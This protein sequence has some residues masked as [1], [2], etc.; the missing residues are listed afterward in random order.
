LINV[1][2]RRVP[3][4]LLDLGRRG[5]F[6]LRHGGIR[7][8]GLFVREE[9]AR[10]SWI[11]LTAGR[12]PSDGGVWCSACGWSGRR[13]MTHCGAGYIVYQAMCPSCGAFPRHRGFA[14]LIDNGLSSELDQLEGSGLRLL[15]APERSMLA[16][17]AP[18]VD[19][20]QGV[21]YAPINDLVE[22][23]EDIQELSFATDSVDFLSCF[24][25][26]EHV[27][28]DNRALRELQR[29]I[30]PQGRA[31]VNVPITFGRRDTIEFGTPNPLLNDHYFDYGEDFTV[32]VV[33]AGLSGT[34]YRLSAVVP[35][36][37]YERMALQD[38]LIYWLQKAHP[39]ENATIVD[40]QGKVMESAEKI[41]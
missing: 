25:V 7:Q 22:Y 8:A 19:R 41:Q 4:K 9:V 16:L 12:A 32:R 14:W 23:R 21:D 2:W 15:F 35:K 37:L 3:S 39:G 10:N 36:S 29:V 5:S 34:A 20:L 26:V 18:H 27:P 33:R 6:I 40:H 13:F 24:H 28:D 17:L 30:S 11:K 1:P 38:E 31:V